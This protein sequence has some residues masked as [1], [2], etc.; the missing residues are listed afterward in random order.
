MSRS[1]NSNKEF[2]FSNGIKIT[3]WS[4]SAKPVLKTDEIKNFSCKGRLPNGVWRLE[5]DIRVISSP[6]TKSSEIANSF[7]IEIVFFLNAFKEPSIMPFLISSILSDKAQQKMSMDQTEQLYEDTIY[8]GG[9]ANE[10]DKALMKK[11]HQ[12][13]WKEKVNLIEKFFL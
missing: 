1:D 6:I 4:N 9:F 5:V 3:F 7:P 10:K 2:A 8:S 12:V 13:D 11:F